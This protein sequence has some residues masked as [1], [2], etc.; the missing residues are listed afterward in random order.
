MDKQFAST[1][2]KVHNRCPSQRVPANFSSW[3]KTLKEINMIVV[4]G[5]A[6]YLQRSELLP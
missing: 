3:S 4:N 1:T 5:W 2:R 6:G